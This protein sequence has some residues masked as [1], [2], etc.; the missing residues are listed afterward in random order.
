MRLSDYSMLSARVACADLI[1]LLPCPPDQFLQSRPCLLKKQ[2]PKAYF[3]WLQWQG[4]C[5]G[6][7]WFHL[8]VR[9][10]DCGGN[11]FVRQDLNQGPVTQDVLLPVQSLQQILVPGLQASICLPI[12]MVNKAN[13]A[14]ITTSKELGTKWSESLLLNLTSMHRGRCTGCHRH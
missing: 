5:S 3:V 7:H 8:L 14:Q 12:L 1:L 9:L 13:A 10:A 4:Y 2:R 11:L 6:N